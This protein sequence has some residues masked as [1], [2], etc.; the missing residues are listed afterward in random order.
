LDEPFKAKEKQSDGGI[1]DGDRQLYDQ[2]VV[3][4]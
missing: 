2:L 4:T 3:L 1:E